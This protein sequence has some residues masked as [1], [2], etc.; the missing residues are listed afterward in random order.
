MVPGWMRVRQLP[1]S[2]VEWCRLQ[3]GPPQTVPDTSGKKES[4]M[5]LSLHSKLMILLLTLFP[6]AGAFAA[7]TNP[8]KGNMNLGTPAQVAGKQ[9]PAGDYVV[10]WDGSG[11]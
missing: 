6:A 9:L 7:T 5:K 1:P 11:P 8:H 2:A 4:C 3:L 10:K